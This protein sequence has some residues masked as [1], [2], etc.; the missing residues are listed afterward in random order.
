MNS[1]TDIASVN[2]HE[3]EKCLKLETELQTDFIEKEIYDKLFNA[4]SQEKDTIIKKLK[5]RIKSLSGKLN[6]DKI[7]KDLEEIETI[8]VEFDHRDYY[9]YWN[10]LR[11]PTALEKETPKPV[12]TLVYSRKPRKSK[13]NVPISKSKVRKSVSANKKEPSPSW[14]SIVSDVPSSSLDEYR[15]SLPN[16]PPL[17][18]FVPTFKNMIRYIVFK[19]LFDDTLTPP[20]SVDLPAPEVITLIDEVV[21][22]VLTVSTGSPSS[23]TVDQDAPSPMARGYRQEEGIDFEDSFAPVANKRLKDLSRCLP[24][25]KTC[26]VYQMDVKTAFL[27]SN[28]QEEV[29]VS[30]SD[31]FTDPDNPNHVCMLKKALYGLKQAPRAWTVYFFKNPRGI[32]LTHQKYALESLKKYG[33]NSCDPVDTPIVEKSKLDEDKEGKA[34]D[35][36][37]YR[38]MIGTLLYLT[39][40]FADAD[41]ADYQDTCRSTYGSMQFLGDRLVSWSSKKAEKRCDIQYES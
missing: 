7:K 3:C 35:L 6:E 38:D 37:H 17:I 14:G 8:N 18:L 28:L 15:T 25:T 40:K 9:N 20:P 4:Q 1:S 10:T 41:H 30:Q 31:G 36:S 26:F 32:L 5:E 27:N 16:P 39:A 21:A 12:V 33:F 24:L 23:T 22:S 29:Y 13:T 34:V 19:P 11:K 2:V